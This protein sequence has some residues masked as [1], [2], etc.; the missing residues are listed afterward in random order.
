MKKCS[1]CGTILLKSNFYKNE[2][3]NDGLNSYCKKCTK[4]YYNENLVEI[5]K[6]II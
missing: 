1:K 2:T 5:K 4:Q 6:K 3:E